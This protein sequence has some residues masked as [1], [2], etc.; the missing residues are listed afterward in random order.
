MMRE[1]LHPFI[2]FQHLWL[3][4]ADAGRKPTLH[5][6]NPAVS[7]LNLHVCSS[8]MCINPNYLSGS[9]PNFAKNPYIYGSIPHLLKLKSHFLRFKSLLPW[10]ESIQIHLSMVHRPP[11][12][13]GST[14]NARVQ[15]GAAWLGATRISRLEAAAASAAL[16]CCRRPEKCWELRDDFSVGRFP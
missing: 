12:L 10:L 1:I 16:H 4:D 8:N 6:S 13:H 5:G 11:T 9:N 3:V 7:H 15:G 14:S 2:S